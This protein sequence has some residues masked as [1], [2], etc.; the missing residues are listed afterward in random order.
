M[1][2]NWISDEGFAAQGGGQELADREDVVALLI[3]NRASNDGQTIGWTQLDGW[4][5][6]PG[7]W[8]DYLDVPNRG[9][10]QIRQRGFVCETART[11]APPPPPGCEGF[12]DDQ[13]GDLAAAGVSC[14]QVAALGCDVDLH[15]VQPSMAA[16]SLVSMFCPIACNACHRTGMA[17]W[18]SSPEQCPWDSIDDRLD[19]VSDTCCGLDA[20]DIACRLG[21]PPETCSPMCSIMFHSLVTDCAE[22][23][24]SLAGPHADSF[25]AFDQLCTSAESVDP[26]VFLDAIAH[27]ECTPRTHDVSRRV[28]LPL[29][30]S[31]PA[32]CS[33]A[34]CHG[35]LDEDSCGA[36]V[37]CGWL[38]PAGCART[39][40]FTHLNGQ[41]NT[42]PT[43]LAGYQ[44]AEWADQDVSLDAGMQIW[45]VPGSGTCTIIAAG[46][47]GG[48]FD[49]NQGGHGAVMQ[50]DFELEA[51]TQLRILVGQ[52]GSDRPDSGDWGAPGGGGTF[53]V[54]EDNPDSNEGI[55]V[56]AGGGAGAPDGDSGGSGFRMTENGD[57]SI[58]TNGRPSDCGASGGRDGQGGEHG[59]GG[60][61]GAGFFGDG[62]GG[63]GNEADA[64][65]FVHG[66]TGTRSSGPSDPRGGQLRGGFGGG[67]GPYNGGGALDLCIMSRL[68]PWQH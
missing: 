63:S 44:G 22:S 57:G 14:Q 47:N 49:G 55:L 64:Q 15:T 53:V 2:T 62:S 19:E 21:A 17:K 32:G 3:N 5:F 7:Q 48:S 31:S 45:T 37:G 8:Y 66:G 9:H 4:R 56:V 20:P 12:V 6:Q 18:I 39:F 1:Y 23:I 28:H 52:R 68:Y 29:T 65:A 40:D 38:E 25:E 43:S 35:C 11:S 33:S 34:H 10:A 24:I 54:R 58:S 61:S 59:G 42:G 13:N 27:A 60:G 36:N 16:G 30:Q 26:L 50:G 46:A 41:G 51:G 67:G